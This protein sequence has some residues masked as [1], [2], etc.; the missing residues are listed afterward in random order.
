MGMAMVFLGRSL[1]ILP[2]TSPMIS[3]NQ[4]KPAPHGAN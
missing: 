3:E 2:R 1:R 4:P